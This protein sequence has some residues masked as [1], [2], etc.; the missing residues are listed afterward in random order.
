MWLAVLVVGGTALAAAL[1]L[2]HVGRGTTWFYDEW[3]WIL[4]R[5]TGTLDDYLANHNGH[6]NLLPIAVYK[7]TWS[8]V[9]LTH[10][11]VLRLFEIALHVGTCLAM[12]VYVRRRTPLWFATGATVVVLFLGYAFQDLLWPLQMTYLGSVLAGLLALLSLDRR[13]G[14]GDIG[15]SIALAASLACSGLGLPFVGAVALELLL[16]RATWRKLWVP[17]VPLILWG[18]WYVQYGQSQVERSNLHLV[19]EHAAQMGSAAVGAL[20]GIAMDDGR[21]LLALLAIAVVVA[22]AVDRRISPRFAAVLSLPIGYWVLTALSRAQYDEPAASRYI[23]PGAVFVVL[24]LA[25]VIPRLERPIG[26]A[27]TAVGAGLLVVLVVLVVVSVRGNVDELRAGAAGLRDTSSYLKAE[28]RAVELARAHVRPDFRP[29][30]LRAPQVDAGGYLRAVDDLGSPAD[31]LPELRHRPGAL[32]DAADAVLLRAL[33]VGLV[34]TAS[35]VGTSPSIG[36]VTGGVVMPS[37]SCA[38]FVPDPTAVDRSVV[39]RATTP[40]VVGSS[41]DS[42]AVSARLL[43]DTMVPVGTIAPGSV[44]VF[45]PVVNDAG[46]WTVQVASSAPVELCAQG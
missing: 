44:E 41:T 16:R 35:A 2:M 21:V 42:V 24:V 4:T 11:T 36:T 34:P 22:L 1:L 29:D 14:A 32:R 45:D 7:A 46:P 43:G 5:R 40:I 3:S 38:R 33:R 30:V 17:L 26:R 9:G 8:L 13:D 25:E 6:L 12:F 39:L 23:Y 28:L 37:G 20:F 31:S 18:V 19:P 27:G 15:A 10:Y